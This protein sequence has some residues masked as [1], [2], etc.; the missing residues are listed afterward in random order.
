MKSKVLFLK[1][2]VGDVSYKMW[3]TS[4]TV[5][6]GVSF[7]DLSFYLYTAVKRQ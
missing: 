2:N 6:H 7:P 4:I 3:Q 1:L 5:V